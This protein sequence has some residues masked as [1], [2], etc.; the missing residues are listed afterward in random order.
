MTTQLVVRVLLERMRRVV[1]DGMVKKISRDGLTEEVVEEA[2]AS[3][4]LALVIGMEGG[5]EQ[6]IQVRTREVY[7]RILTACR[8]HAMPNQDAHSL[9]FIH[10]DRM[11]AEFEAQA[12]RMADAGQL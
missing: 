1:R 8:S 9:A 10:L 11:V 4:L 6:E 12:P 7:D 2:C 3:V 5:L